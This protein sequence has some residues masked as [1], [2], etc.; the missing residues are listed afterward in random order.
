VGGIQLTN[1]N[2]TFPATGGSGSIAVAAAASCPW[3]VSGL[4]AWVSVPAGT[5]GTG[6]GNFS[7][8][9]AANIATARSGS[10]SVNGSGVASTFNLSQAASP[11]TTWSITPTSV[12]APAGNSTGSLAV[13]AD[14]SCSWSVSAL[15]SWMTPTSGTSGTGN[16]T[17][18]YAIAA[19][20]G[21]ARSATATMTG[22]GPVRYVYLNQAASPCNSWSIS[23]A[24][25]NFAAAGASGSLAVTADSSCSWSL[26]T[27]PSWMAASTGTSGAGNGSIGYTVAANTGAARSATATLSGS[28]PSKPVSLSQASGIVVV[29]SST[30]IGTGVPVNGALQ[31]SACSNGARG[32]G[33][34]TDRYTFTG[35]PGQAVTILLTAASFDTYLYLRD[36][37]GTVIKSDDDGGGGTNSR[38]PASSGTYTLPAG[39]S[40]TYTIEVTSYSQN[41][42]GAY[43]LSFT[44]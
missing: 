33:Y 24:T 28:G 18:S 29:C 14:S 41:K 35:A 3:T 2:A 26:S 34:Y 30:P 6:P 43:T 15:P 27:L 40:G 12:T 16:G 8:T 36:P 21:A 37:A 38:I 32:A 9:V 10:G 22:S 11:C 1:S 39:S 4:P 20:A 44:Q 23:P 5:G 31:T 17:I 7:F 25:L 13:T 19:N 42:T